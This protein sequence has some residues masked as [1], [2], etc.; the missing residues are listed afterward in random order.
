MDVDELVRQVAAR[1]KGSK[2][3]PLTVEEVDQV[4]RATL[5]LLEEDAES[6]QVKSGDG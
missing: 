6:T 1:T 3:D 5:A 2:G 4:V